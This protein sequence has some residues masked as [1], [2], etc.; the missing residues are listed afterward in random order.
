MSIPL[1]LCIQLAC[2]NAVIEHTAILALA[3]AKHTPTGQQ[4]EH[5]G[6]I[7][8]RDTEFGPVYEW[9]EARPEG[10][11]ATGVRVI[12]TALLHTG[13]KVVAT[14]HVHLCLNGYFHDLYSR[15]DIIG[16]FFSRVPEYM[17]DSCT[18]LVHVFDAAVDKVRDTGRD[19]TLQDTGEVVYHLPAGR[20]IGDIHETEAG[21]DT[22]E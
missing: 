12:D 18:G 4:V 6:M 8:E 2:P 5:G 15:T 22:D 17:L 7:I 3:T 13:E 16:A 20:I 19:V 11:T 14:Y 1:L 21:I 9:R 10:G